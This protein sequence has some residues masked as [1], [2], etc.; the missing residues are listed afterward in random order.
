MPDACAVLI[1]KLKEERVK[2]GLT[3]KKLAEAARLTQSVIARLESKKAIPQLDTLLKVAAAL[4]C[5]LRLY[6]LSDMNK[7]ARSSPKR[8]FLML[9]SFSAF[10]YC[11]LYHWA[12]YN[13]VQFYIDLYGFI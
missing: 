6:P 11:I 12:G 9:S 8:V 10:A 5:N 3:Q 4:G 2:K 13:A 7:P 1:D